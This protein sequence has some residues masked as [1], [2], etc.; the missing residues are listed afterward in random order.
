MSEEIKTTTKQD[1]T[2]LSKVVQKVKYISEH[3]YDGNIYENIMLIFNQLSIRER[4]VLLR[5]LIGFC[6]IVEDQLLLS[7][8]KDKIPEVAKVMPVK[9]VT[10]KVESELQDLNTINALELIKLK[11]WF[12]RTV[13]WVV[14]ICVILFIVFNMVV[15]DGVTPAF[16]FFNDIL[17]IFKMMIG[18]SD[19]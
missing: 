6:F 13:T 19:K 10:G 2:T 9:E 14:I 7:S 11:S 15:S 17:S 18:L 16:P 12:F 3:E 8:E 4:T 5:G 1:K